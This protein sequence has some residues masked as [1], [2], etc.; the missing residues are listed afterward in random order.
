MTERPGHGPDDIVRGL[1]LSRRV[2][3]VAAGL[4]GLTGATLLGT[5]WATEPE[6]LPVRTELAFMAL[7]LIGITWAVFAAVAL[8]R[9]PLFALDRMVAA[10][11]AVACS[12]LATVGIVAIALTRTNLIALV[13]AG[14]SGLTLI[15]VASAMVIRARAYRAALL[16]RRHE[17][18]VQQARSHGAGTP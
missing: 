8:I 17:L 5:L 16:A 10:W 12:T 1:S 13:T 4:G 6:Q 7:I 3:Y 9:R 2:G 14:S 15:V 11:L 18:E